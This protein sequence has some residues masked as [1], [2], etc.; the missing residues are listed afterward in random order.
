[1]AGQVRVGGRRTL[2][3]RA[4]AF[5]VLNRP[6]FAQPDASIGTVVG[7]T[8]QFIPAPLFGRITGA[9]G[10]GFAGGGIGPGTP[11][12]GAR[13]IQLVVRLNF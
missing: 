1:M 7:A 8:G 11:T 12:G 3:F 6:S 2:Q 10:L 9:G 13:T 4:E 5:N